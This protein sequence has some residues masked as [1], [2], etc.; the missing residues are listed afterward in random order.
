[1]KVSVATPVLVESIG[2][3]ASVAATKSPKP[4]LECVRLVADRK[5]GLSLEAT[6]LDVGIRLRVPDAQ[7]T[8]DGEVLVSASRLLSVVREV[9]EP[10]TSLTQRDGSLA[11]DTGRSRFRI[12]I[13]EAEDFPE[14][15]NLAEDAASTLP[16]ASLRSMI[17]RTVFATAKEVGR[18]PFHGVLFRLHGRT[19]ELVAT[20][21]RRLAKAVR[22]LDRPVARE[23]KVIVGPKGLSVLDRVMPPEGGEVSLAVQERQVAFRVGNALVV[24]RLIDGSFPAYEDVIPKAS[25]KSFAAPVEKLLAGLRRASL[26]TT[27]DSISVQFDV[28]PKQLTIRSRALEVGQAEV[29]VDIAYAGP[30]EKLGFNPLF[31]VDALKVM[32]PQREVR[33][34]FSNGKAP[35]KLTDGDDFV[36]VVMPIALE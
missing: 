1:M 19:L 17:R 13:E 18:F 29:E 8:A 23:V 7:V 35:G 4:A 30:A 28:A 31:L 21:G 6:D 14:I 26:L 16:G 32:D 12:R 33:F 25:D 36:Y 15:P 3:A 2:H 5:S 11:V 20:D 22:A 27:R 34:E 9:D 24:S 10:E